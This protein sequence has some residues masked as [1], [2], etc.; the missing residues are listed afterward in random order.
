MPTALAASL[1]SKSWNVEFH[2]VP[3][4]SSSNQDGVGLFRLSNN[5]CVCVELH[6]VEF[7]SYLELSTNLHA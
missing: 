5:V 1:I 6:V 2:F 4:F 3:D 7:F